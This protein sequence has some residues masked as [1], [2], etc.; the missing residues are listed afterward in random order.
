MTAPQRPPVDG[1]AR[2]AELLAAAYVYATEHGLTDLSLR[3]LAT[4]I[5][6]SPRVL[7]Y[8]FGSKDALVR[9]VLSV[10]RQEQLAF[11]REAAAGL[12]GRGDAHYGAVVQRL[13]TWV[14]AGHRR[15]LVRLF[16]EAFAQ[17]ARTDPGPWE[18]FAE[19]SVRDLVAALTHA[20]P[21]VPEP[22]ATRRATATLALLRGLILHLLAGGDPDE[23]GTLLI[24]FGLLGPDAA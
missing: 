6:S 10:A 4:A 5:G 19:Q 15:G 12:P 9:E 16:V 7:L 14:S 13:W 21:D 3:P 17:S 18:G 20:Q 1:S 11:I 8:L 24:E 23:L 22:A 2:R